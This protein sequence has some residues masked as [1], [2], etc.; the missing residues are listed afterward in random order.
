MGKA[1]RAGQPLA[2]GLS[3]GSLA[4]EPLTSMGRRALLGVLVALLGVRCEGDE[5]VDLP[6]IPTDEKRY[7]PGFANPYQQCASLI[8]REPGA[9][10]SRSLRS[11]PPRF[12]GMHSP[13]FPACR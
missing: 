4:S 2:V 12:S 6:P 8:P 7:I 1:S 11:R 3:L 10:L 9:Y 13:L 5:V